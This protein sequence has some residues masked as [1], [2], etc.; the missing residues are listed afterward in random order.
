MGEPRHASDGA[1]GTTR[2]AARSRPR[3]PTPTESRPTE[4]ADR[5]AAGRAVLA[6]LQSLAGN[7]AVAGLLTGSR[8]SVQRLVGTIPPPPVTPSAPDPAQ[9]PGFRAATGRLAGARQQTRSHPPARRQAEAAGRAAKPP[10]DDKE[11]Q[12][13][14][15]KAGEMGAAP[16][17]GFDKAAFIAAVSAAIAKQAPKNL[18]EADKFSDSDKSGAVAAEVKGKV[19]A[20]KDASAKPMADASEKAPDES[21]AIDKPVT[22]LASPPGPGAPAAIDGEAAMPTRAPAEQ[23]ELGN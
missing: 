8:R 5:P 2:S 9:H 14:A 15:T 6:Q 3:V 21:K 13:K 11:S 4:D 17:G 10:T 18:E 12:A 1:A 16:V 20:S 7:A 22:P 19:T 23:T